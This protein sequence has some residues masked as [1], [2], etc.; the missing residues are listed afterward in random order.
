MLSL[1]RV[2]HCPVVETIMR[3]SNKWLILITCGLVCGA[4][5]LAYRRNS[6]QKPMSR[7]I[8]GGAIVQRERIDRAIDTASGLNAE[9]AIAALHEYSE[10]Y[11]VAQ[12]ASLTPSSFGICYFRQV[13]ADRRVSKIFE[14]FL[15]L[16]S[17]D[18]SKQA[19][20]MFDSK[21]ALLVS[22]WNK[23]ANGQFAG[24]G[25][26]GPLHHATSVGAFFCSYFCSPAVLDEKLNRWDA[27]VVSD[28]I[29]RIQGV[30]VMAINRFVDPLFRLNLLVISGVRNGASVEDLNKE[31]D[32]ITRKIT[33]DSTPFLQV[34]SINLFKWDAETLDTDFTHVTRGVPASGKSILLKL[35]GFPDPN[36]S[37]FLQDQQVFAALEK[38][39]DT[40]RRGDGRN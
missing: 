5:F 38:T 2:F 10:S 35:P 13:L 40:W 8:S 12:L 4:I 37:L 24:V 39:I 6:G 1:I 14:A 9:S 34:E 19:S 21:L 11:E 20:Q 29:D 26:F 18:S 15:S 22:E 3:L 31:L 33:G 36:S 16:N 30:E 23:Q 17:E 25:N 28:A 27:S 7:D 32:S